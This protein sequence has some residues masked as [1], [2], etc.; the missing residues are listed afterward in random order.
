MGT[1]SAPLKTSSPLETLNQPSGSVRLVCGPHHPQTPDTTSHT[2]TSILCHHT[3]THTCTHPHTLI[4]HHS[5]R[6]S[7]RTKHRQIPRSHS[8]PCRPTV[9]TCA[10]ADGHTPS[11][12]HCDLQ[13][14]HT[15]SRRDPHSRGDLH[16][17]ASITHSPS[18]T[19]RPYSEHLLCS[20]HRAGGRSNMAPQGLCKVTG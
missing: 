13:W 5:L 20:G 2:V 10:G 6:G 9:T 7:F 8:T 18:L 4:D 11:W 16:S 12:C 14:S 15:C 19:C 1:F 3:H 17:C